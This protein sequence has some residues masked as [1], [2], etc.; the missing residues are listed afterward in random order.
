MASSDESVVPTAAQVR[1]VELTSAASQMDRSPRGPLLELESDGLKSNWGLA[2]SG[3]SGT[4]PQVE[5][6]ECRSS[7]QP[8]AHRQLAPAQDNMVRDGMPGGTDAGAPE[9]ARPG[10]E[11]VP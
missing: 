5:S 6:V 3:N 10:P 7:N 9:L 8:P 2:L 11:S 4:W 1:T